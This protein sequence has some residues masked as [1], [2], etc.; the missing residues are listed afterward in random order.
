MSLIVGWPLQVV[1][2][3]GG[4]DCNVG[5]PVWI[6]ISA[7]RV[8]RQKWPGHCSQRGAQPIK[9]GRTD[10]QPLGSRDGVEVDL[11]LK[12]KFNGL[13]EGRIVA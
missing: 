1:G 4:K 9:V 10:G 3:A 2:S 7:L 6:V 5:G 12:A 11:V 13:G 8:V